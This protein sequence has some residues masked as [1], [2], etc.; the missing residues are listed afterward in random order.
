M[1]IRDRFGG[2]LPPLSFETD[3]IW[4][5]SSDDFSL[6]LS[7]A[8]DSADAFWPIAPETAGTL[9]VLC[10]LAGAKGCLL[11]NS[12]ADA[13]EKTTSK[14]AS[15]YHL[16]N[17]GIV[18]V[19]T[20]PLEECNFPCHIDMV[21]KPDDGVGC[22]QTLL[23]PSG[24]LPPQDLPAGTICQPFVEGT[25]GSISIIYSRTDVCV[26]SV[27]RQH[28]LVKDKHFSLQVCE[29]NALPHLI[30]EATEFAHAI[31]QVFPEL[32]GYVGVDFIL[33]NSGM[34][35]L[36]INPRVTTSFVGLEQSIS[37][38]PSALVLSAVRGEVLECPRSDKTV[39]VHL[40]E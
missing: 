7:D 20:Q 32:L 6:M 12:S 18:S 24:E 3:L 16:F 14:L 15:Y 19:E 17:N 29:V 2:R 25:V 33:T 4:V 23:I 27:N 40:N 22:E 13:V 36:E 5:H 8:L 35:V 28:V 26:L 21:V 11:L 31:H 9:T 34:S 1:C 39:E 38:N 10:R 30:G 37:C